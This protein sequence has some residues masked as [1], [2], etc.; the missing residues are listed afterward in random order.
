MDTKAKPQRRRKLRV[1]IVEGQQPQM[2][3]VVRQPN[4]QNSNSSSK[5]SKRRQR[6]RAAKNKMYNSAYIE[7]RPMSISYSNSND[8]RRINKG[9]TTAMSNRKLTPDGLSFLKCA[10]SPPDFAV[11]RVLGVPDDYEAGSLV[12]KHKL[13]L[14]TSFSASN[15]VYILLAPVPGIA[16]Y[17]LTKSP[18]NA[19]NSSD[20]WQPVSYSEYGN[21]FGTGGFGQDVSNIITGFRYVSNHIE[22]VPTVNQMTWTGSITAIKC[23][24]KLVS[25]PPDSTSGPNNFYAITGLEAA[26]EVNANVYVGPFINGV[27]S[28]AFSNNCKFDFTNTIERMDIVPQNISPGDFGQLDKIPSGLFPASSFN[29]PMTGFDNGF[30]SIILRLQ[31]MSPSNNAIIRTWACVEYQVNPGNA[32]YPLMT[33]SCE[34]KLAI[35]LYR[36]IIKELPVG[37]TYMDNPDFWKRVLA[38]IRRISGPLSLIPGPYGVLASG[39]NSIATGI[40]GLAF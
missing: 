31:G 6:Q 33:T 11:T 34:D 12:M 40:E 25:R 22:I 17:T 29:T 18:G 23:P 2:A 15:D 4:G 26:N 38:I 16:F 10:F 1:Q 5:S 21:L 13:N 24:V 36:K 27:Y 7:A 14:A 35:D 37:V 9:L 30:E 19:V 20:V 39:V 3:V 28:G 8:V 32:F